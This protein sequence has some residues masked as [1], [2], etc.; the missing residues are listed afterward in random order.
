MLGAKI[1]N[2]ADCDITGIC[3]P[4]SATSQ[5]VTFLTNKKHRGPV[6][7]CPCAA[8]L[9]RRGD[10]VP[11]K[12]C[13]EVE[14]PY[15]GYARVAQAFE[16]RSS[17]WGQGISSSAIIDP[18]AI[19]SRSVSIGPQSVIGAGVKIGTDTAIGAH[20]VIERGCTIG[21][22]CRIDSGVVIRHKCVVGNRVI[23]QSGTVIG[24]DGFANAR[25]SGKF[26]RIP[27]FGNVVI[28]DDVDIGANTAI[29]RGNF[30]PTVIGRGV[31][32]DN[33]VHIAHN[34]TIGDDSAIA[35]QTGFAGSTKIGKRVLMG[36]QVG[37]IGHIEVGD[38]VFIGAKAGVSKNI[39]PGSQVTGYPARDL[40]TMR[41]IEA[42]ESA[43][44]DLVR[45]VR[46]IRK[47]LDERK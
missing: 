10:T 16:D 18:A 45:E 33:L 43:L 28:G 46:R 44:P 11:G 3:S 38:D 29:D 7:A 2:G 15:V 8:V 25:E 30:E 41:R 19:I 14:D 31:K 22:Q 1:P 26:I 5:H 17:P 42:A 32:I 40:M 34:I 6:E 35:A 20:C 9:V 37:V 23:I 4:Q 12:V 24:S 21:E 39:E 36:G 13:I 47:E 27:C